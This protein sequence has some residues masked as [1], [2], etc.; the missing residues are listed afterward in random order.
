MSM[1]AEARFPPVKIQRLTCDDAKRLR[2]I[3]LR[4]LVDSPD[5][6]ATTVEEVASQTPEFWERQ[7]EQLATFVAI[8][9]AGDVGIVRGHAMIIA[10]MLA[11]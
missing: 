5:A 10:V 3:R 11:I 9:D 1:N 7:L 4:A 8:G 6:F 2:E